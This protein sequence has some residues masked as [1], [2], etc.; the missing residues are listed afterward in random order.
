MALLRET[1][2]PGV[3]SILGIH[4]LGCREDTEVEMLGGSWQS[5]LSVREER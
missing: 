3:S 1:G 5:G 2:G 4:N